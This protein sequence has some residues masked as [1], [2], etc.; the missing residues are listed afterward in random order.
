[1]PPST[2]ALT[3]GSAASSSRTHG[4]SLSL[5]KLIMPRQMRDT[6]RPVEPRLTYFKSG[7]RLLERGIIYGCHEQVL[8]AGCDAQGVTN[9]ACQTVARSRDGPRGSVLLRRPRTY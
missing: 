1:M 5:P 9:R 2:A 3:I 4:R 6:R 8:R 7:L